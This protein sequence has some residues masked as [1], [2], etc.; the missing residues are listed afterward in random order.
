MTLQAVRCRNFHVIARS[1]RKVK[2]EHNSNVLHAAAA[3][4]HEQIVELLLDKGA[5]VNAQGGNYGN[6]LLA[7]SYRG[8][9]QTVELLLDEGAELGALVDQ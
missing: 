9:E 3:R 6:A 8:H 4:G 5:E 7:A 1:T 2:Y